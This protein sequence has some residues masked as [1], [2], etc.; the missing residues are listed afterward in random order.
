MMIA[1]DAALLLLYQFYHTVKR[2]AAL[3]KIESEEKY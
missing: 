3:W 1:E 2:K